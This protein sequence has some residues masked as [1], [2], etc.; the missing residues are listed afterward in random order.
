MGHPINHSTHSGFS[1]PPSE[2]ITAWSIRSFERSFPLLRV[3]AA[4]DDPLLALAHGVGHIPLRAIIA[5]VGR[6]AAPRLGLLLIRPLPASIAQGVGYNFTSALNFGS[7][8]LFHLP[9]LRSIASSATGVCQSFAA[10]DS[11]HPELALA[12]GML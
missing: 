5:S 1:W 6:S 8:R 3:S 2:A 9:S 10:L 7:P 4:G 12:P 11:P